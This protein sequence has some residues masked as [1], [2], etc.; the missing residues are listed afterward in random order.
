MATRFKIWLEYKYSFLN[1]LVNL[2]LIL[3][4]K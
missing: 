2:K 4:N 1:M 3:Q